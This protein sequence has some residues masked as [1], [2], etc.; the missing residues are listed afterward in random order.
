MVTNDGGKTYNE[1]EF[2][3]SKEIPEGKKIFTDLFPTIENGI[4][5]VNVFTMN[6]GFYEPH[7]SSY[8]YI[9]KD[10]GKTFEFSKVL[11]VQ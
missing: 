1:V 3:R 7:R 10:N 8:E 9:S 11:L 4:L 5:K 6:N 2:I